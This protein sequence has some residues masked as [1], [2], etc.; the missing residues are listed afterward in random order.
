MPRIDS[1]V[2]KPALCSKEELDEF[3]RL[4]RQGGEVGA[5]G[6]KDRVQ[7]ARALVFLRLDGELAGVAGLKEPSPVYRDGV[8]RKALV[9]ATSKVFRLELGWVF[10]PPA[11]RRK[12]YSLV[13]SGAAISQSDRAPTFAT[14]RL[15]NVAMQ[16]TLEHVGLRRLGESWQSGRGAR[17]W[18]V[19]YV[20][21]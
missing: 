12:G 15:D 16:R 11:H 5:D 6:L 20:T 3:C 4:V 9:P 2:K 17:P 7:R 21:E 1:I 19:L 10:V 18:L 8:F 14:T 13:L